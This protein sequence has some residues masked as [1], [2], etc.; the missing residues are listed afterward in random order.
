MTTFFAAA[1][2]ETGFRSLFSSC[3]APEAHR[4]IY[5]LKG[6]PG[7]GK[8][9]LMKQVGFAAEANGYAVEYFRC[10]SD[11]DSL[12]AV[13]IPALG[14]AVLDGTAPHT[15]DPAF[16]GAVERIVNLGEAFDNKG[17]EKERE[18]ILSLCKAKSEAY[19]T[20]YRFLAAAGRMAH[21]REE[22]LIP[23]FLSGKAEAAV[24]RLSETLKKAEKGRE[25]RRYLSA[26]GTRGYI[27]LDTLRKKARKVY[28]VT[29]KNGLEYLFMTHLHAAFLRAGLAMTVCMTPLVDSQIEAIYIESEGVLFAVTEESAVEPTDKIINSARFVMKDALSKRRARLRFSEKCMKGLMEGALTSLAE[30]GRLHGKLEEIYGKHIDFSVV[31]RVKNR[32]ISEIFANN[33]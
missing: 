27:K 14:I 23:A 26:I 25:C 20:A 9:T 28:A 31:E 19:R 30:A 2:T 32:I 17:L 16:P 29:E 22:L 21:E 13:R 18:Q 33:M 15:T 3:F 7:T 5:I 11:T 4:R 1:N 12:D 10:S 24:S 8:S 6:G